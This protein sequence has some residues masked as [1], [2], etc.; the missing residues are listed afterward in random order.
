MHI[1]SS[2]HSSL[3]SRTDMCTCTSRSLGHCWSSKVSICAISQRSQSELAVT[4]LWIFPCPRARLFEINLPHLAFASHRLCWACS[5]ATDCVLTTSF[6]SVPRSLSNFRDTAP[7][8]WQREEVPPSPSLPRAF[9]SSKC[10]MLTRYRLQKCPRQAPSRKKAS[11]TSRR[12]NT[13]PWTCHLYQITFS[14]ITYEPSSY[15]RPIPL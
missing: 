12:T 4:E 6:S 3:S 9:T 14:G 2:I 7:R 13:P 8:Q 11:N 5:G 1:I 15:H 10:S